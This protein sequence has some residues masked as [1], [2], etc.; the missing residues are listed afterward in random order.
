[1]PS[2]LYCQTQKKKE[3]NRKKEKG[4]KKEKKKHSPSYKVAGVG[5]EEKRWGFKHHSSSEAFGSKVILQENRGTKKV[6]WQPL[7]K[8]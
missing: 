8:S 1:M 5:W 6:I 4:K 7:R 3:K 2:T